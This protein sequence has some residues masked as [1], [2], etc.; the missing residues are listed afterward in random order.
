[1]E[2][3]YEEITISV[4]SFVCRFVASMVFAV[5]ARFEKMVPSKERIKFTRCEESETLFYCVLDVS[6]EDT[7]VS[8][9][10][11]EKDG[12]MKYVYFDARRGVFVATD[13]RRLAIRPVKILYTKGEIPENGLYINPK[14]LKIGY[15]AIRTIKKDG[16][17]LTEMS[18]GA[19]VLSCCDYSGRY[20]NYNSI[21]FEG[22]KAIRVLDVKIFSAFV[23]QAAKDK[24]CKL[25]IETKTGSGRMI[26]SAVERWNE[27]NVLSKIEVE[28]LS[29]APCTAVF[30]FDPAELLPALNGWTGELFL[31]ECWTCARLGSAI[32]QTVVAYCETNRGYTPQISEVIEEAR[33]VDIMTEPE[34]HNIASSDNKHSKK[35]IERAKE[36]AHLI[37]LLRRNI[38]KRNSDRAIEQNLKRFRMLL[39]DEFFR[40]V[41]VLV[42]APKSCYT[43]GTLTEFYRRCELLAK[44]ENPYEALALFPRSDNIREREG[45]PGTFDAIERENALVR[46]SAQNSHSISPNTNSYGR[47][48]VY[49]RRNTGQEFQEKGRIRR[50]VRSWNTRSSRREWRGWIRKGIKIDCRV[51]ML[52]YSHPCRLYFPA[53][54]SP[55]AYIYPFHF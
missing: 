22:G 47:N 38:E 2:N 46:S 24:D 55:P 20:P 6:K 53:P 26:I 27:D 1:M 34:R 31:R 43:Y 44:F 23:K 25:R 32:G 50:P 12:C 29:P 18:Q 35:V 48:S 19:Q 42:Y 45:I 7:E 39:H 16:K 10:A 40:S 28:L 51:Y 49:Y 9:F 11:G 30:G 8:K 54:N 36:F 33:R 5:L 15:C 3:G 14:T 13:G 17:L 52:T 37:T 21:L 4:E 41:T